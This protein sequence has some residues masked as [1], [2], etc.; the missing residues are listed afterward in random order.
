MS[1]LI[2]SKLLLQGAG[3]L[4]IAL[5]WSEA[6]KK[7]IDYIIP[8]PQGEFIMTL[9][10]AMTVTLLIAIFIRMY[11]YG[12]KWKENIDN[13][14]TQPTTEGFTGDPKMLLRR[15]AA[16]MQKLADN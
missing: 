1:R 3:S 2:D 4:I 13:I 12:E 10:Y 14:K 9:I 11:N 16:Q 7:F 8:N 5:A 15:Y 6:A